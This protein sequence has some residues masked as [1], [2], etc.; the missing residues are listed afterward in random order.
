MYR[1]IVLVTIFIVGVALTGT[2]RAA[3]ILVNSTA[4]NAIASDG[5]CTLREAI[6]NADADVDTTGGDCPAGSGEDFITI[7]VTSAIVLGSNLP[8]ITDPDGL[9]IDGGGTAISVISA[10]RVLGL[11]G[12]K[13]EA[14]GY[15]VLNHLTI[16]QGL[17]LDDVGAGIYNEGFLGVLSCA[18]SDN[19]ITSHFDPSRGP[20]SGG[21]GGAGIY[22]SGTL[23]VERSRFA[24]NQDSATVA[25]FEPSGLAGA[26][27]NDN[28]ASATVSDTVFINN[29]SNLWG[30]AISN[31]QDG[32]LTVWR[33]TFL[34]NSGPKGGG[35]YNRGASL[36]VKDSAFVSNEARFGGGLYNT[37]PPTGEAGPARVVNSTFV[38]HT[39]DVEEG[40]GIYNSQALL[41]VSHS[42]LTGNLGSG[43][44][45]TAGGSLTLA[46]TI[47]ADSLLGAPDCVND[48][49]TIIGSG[50]NLIKDGSCSIPGALTGN[51]RLGRLMGRP[52]DSLLWSTPLRGLLPTSPA[53]DIADGAVCAAAPVNGRDQ[54]GVPRPQ[55]GGCDIG[56]FEVAGF[57]KVQPPRELLT[58][59]TYTW[60]SNGQQR[61]GVFHLF[62]DLTFE[63]GEGDRGTWLTEGS[64]LP[65]VLLTRFDAGVRCEAATVARLD[66]NLTLTGVFACQDGTELKGFIVGRG[67]VP[68][69]APAS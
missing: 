2:T 54:R 29:R 51:P 52:E 12:L 49:G 37:D 34:E 53:R 28:G 25:G 44:Y 43:V 45:N 69:A 38:N 13:V 3:S 64:E 17:L 7:G 27:F 26:I 14:T 6:G 10:N 8:A 9:W 42:T 32:S 35:I 5:L 40:G 24:D 57:D 21:L 47:I 23:V 31:D 68:P 56:A 58:I 18:I 60:M 48:S 4:D 19:T 65:A 55:G 33:S 62:E 66:E 63:D 59:D 20:G 41:T 67:R 30:G 36:L 46:N 15:L 22:N 11:R 1:K 61:S 16:A 50:V 39:E